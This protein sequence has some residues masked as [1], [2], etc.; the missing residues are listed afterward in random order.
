MIA[1]AM[2]RASILIDIFTIQ[3]FHWMREKEYCDPDFH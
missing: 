2:D 3:E 1:I